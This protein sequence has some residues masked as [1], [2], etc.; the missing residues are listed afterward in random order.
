MNT[1]SNYDVTAPPVPIGTPAPVNVNLTVEN[2]VYVAAGL[3]CLLAKIRHYESLGAL[4]HMS[5][6]PAPFIEPQHC[7]NVETGLALPPAA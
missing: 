7:V 1:I 4:T 3:T 5:G 2:N 6:L